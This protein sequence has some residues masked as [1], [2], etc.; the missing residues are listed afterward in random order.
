MKKLKNL[1][2]NKVVCNA[3]WLV[4]GTVANKL[5]AFIVSVCT[6]RYLGPS[7][8]GLINYA[9]AF[10]TFFFSIATL[11]I[12]SVIIKKLIDNPEK[13]GTT[14]GT[15]LVLQGVS[16]LLSIIM[17]LL[18][19]FVIDYGEKLTITVVFL[20]SLGLFFQVLDSVKY[21]FQSKLQSK[22][23][24]VS[25]TLSYIASSAYKIVLLMLNKSVE[26]FALAAT[27]DYLC[28]AVILFFIYKKKGGPRLRFSLEAA[29]DLLGS[30]Y[31]YILSGL[32]VS[33]YGI[34][35]K[36]MLKQMLN[37]ETVGLYGTALALSNMWVFVLA[38]V[39]DSMNPVITEAKKTDR[40][41][42]IKKNIQL[43]RI[44]FYLTLTVNIVIT[45]FAD[46]GINLL[47][48]EAYAG[49][50]T[51]LRIV[52]WYVSASYLGV[53]RGIWVVCENKQKFLTPIY[54]ASA[55]INVALNAALIPLFGA[56]GAAIA[57]LVTQISTVFAVPVFIKEMRPNVKMMIDAI[58][59][60]N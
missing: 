17:I 36:L 32:M 56:S 1:L 29:K 22:Y 34:T 12:N 23:V 2:H 51:P 55:V 43:Y 13:E 25:T 39:I 3:G 57:S 49:A 30:S 21:W 8:Y 60:R 7:N 11:G 14:L 6:A 46:F 42:Y 44:V 53:A 26:W 37:E 16:S 59:F 50:V 27:V 40:E 47:Y 5:I 33:V 28:V 41:S 45:I 4:L 35:D 52:N 9:G 18:I 38:A 19:V 24:A 48:G 20:Y 10:L 15:T 58:T 54:L 31:H